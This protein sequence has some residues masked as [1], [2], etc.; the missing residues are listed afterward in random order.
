ML[1]LVSL[2]IVVEQFLPGQDQEKVLIH[3]HVV[4]LHHPVQQL[5]AAAATV[6]HRAV[7]ALRQSNEVPE[8]VQVHAVVVV[9][10]VHV[11]PLV[12]VQEV[13]EEKGKNNIT[14]L[15]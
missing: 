10:A 3:H 12:Q 15:L 11:V 14:L 2:Q 8:V 4:I 6:R 7:Q 9:A 1:E 13:A 5:R